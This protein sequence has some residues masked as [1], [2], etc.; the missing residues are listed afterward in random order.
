[1]IED[2]S[3]KFFI[4][5]NEL[6][7]VWLVGVISCILGVQINSMPLSETSFIESK[8]PNFFREGIHQ[9]PER[10]KVIKNN[11]DIISNIKCELV[12][13]WITLN[14]RH[15]INLYI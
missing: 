14:K 8:P 6:W 3:T 10:S 1:M 11:G 12:L 15:R 9:L 4:K 13:V 7:I 2:F 5:N